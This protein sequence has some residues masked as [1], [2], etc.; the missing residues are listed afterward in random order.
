MRTPRLH[1]EWPGRECYAPSVLY[2]CATPIGNLGDVTLRLLETLRAVAVIACEDTR[3]TL[4]LLSRYGIS[5]P[6]LLSLHEHNEERR[7]GEILELLREG[8]DVALV[9][10]AGTPT[11]SDPGFR[12]VRACRD[13]GLPLTALPGPSAGLTALVLSGLPTDRFLF[14]GFLPRDKRRLAAVVSD[15]ASVQATLVAF[16]SPR[17]VRGLLAELCELAPDCRLALCRELTKLHEEV[18]RGTPEEVLAVLPESVR[19]EIAV[20][21][22][23]EKSAEISPVGPLDAAQFVQV[24]MQKGMFARDI[25][26]TVAQVLGMSR[27]QAYEL[28]LDHQRTLRRA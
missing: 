12:L 24:L 23:A 18:L 16:E 22:R 19:G 7:L 27:N 5:G 17:R 25:A 21:L 8:T 1:P 14:V 20:V 9:S 10:D 4:K 13:E 15:A 11:F 2:V 3:H 26:D 6:R 28:V